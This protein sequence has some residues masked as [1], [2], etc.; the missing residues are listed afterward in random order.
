MLT[1][2][3][4]RRIRVNPEQGA[5]WAGDRSQ[6]GNTA[7]DPRA[8][9]HACAACRCDSGTPQLSFATTGR[10]D[11]HGSAGGTGGVA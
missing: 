5:G 2:F 10:L 6:R 9:E 8:P 1:T 3:S 4:R 7:A 11:S